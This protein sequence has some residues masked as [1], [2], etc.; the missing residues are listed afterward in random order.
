MN[1]VMTRLLRSTSG[2]PGTWEEVVQFPGW[3]GIA[4][5]GSFNGALYVGSPLADDGLS[6]PDLAQLRRDKLGAGDHG[7]LR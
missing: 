6:R 7:W 2:D 3:D 1:L 5:Y 4:A